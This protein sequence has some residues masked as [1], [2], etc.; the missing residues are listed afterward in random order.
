MGVLGISREEILLMGGDSM[1]NRSPETIQCKAVRLL[2][3][4]ESELTAEIEEL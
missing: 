1:S 2:R 4:N 3:I